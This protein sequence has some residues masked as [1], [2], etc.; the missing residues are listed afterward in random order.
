MFIHDMSRSAYISVLAG[1][2][3]LSAFPLFAQKPGKERADELFKQQTAIRDSYSEIAADPDKAGTVYYI[4][5]HNDIPACTKAPKGFK[6]FYISH[7]GRHG[8]RNI[9]SNSDVRKNMALFREAHELGI[10]TE[11]GEEYLRRYEKAYPYLDGFGSDLTGLGAQSQHTIAKNMYR[12]YP[13]VF[14]KGAKID[15][16]STIVPRCIL[17]MSAFCEGL[18]EEDSSLQISQSAGENTM[19]YLNPFTLNNPDVKPTDEGYDNKNAYWQDAFRR[20]LKDAADAEKV[21][22][23]LITDL[24]ILSKYG[25]REDVVKRFFAVAQA[26]QCNENVKDRFWDFIPIEETYKLWDALNYRYFCSKGADTLFQKGRQ[27]AFAWTTLQNIV[28]QAEEDMA[29]GEI[30]ARLRFGHDIIAMSLFALMDIPGY[31]IPAAN[32]GQVKDV[33]RS[34]DFPM[35]LNIQF[36]FYKNKKGEVLVRMMYN[37]K[38]MVLP[39]ES[40]LAPYYRW[41]DFKRYAAKRIEV[42]RGI[43]ATTQAPPEKTAAKKMTTIDLVN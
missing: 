30:K 36:V 12:H 20:R 10:L 24:S 38:D 41:E 17:T 31:N 2:L 7:Y 4:Y 8:E 14:P 29:T 5:N 13:Q 33:F 6:P 9:S 3:L 40:D 18:K 42:A 21:F 28:D 25:S 23:P 34:Y 43:I 39:I 1:T 32:A 19:Y 16:K 22:G 35:A 37:E 15:A 27:W 11:K 26:V